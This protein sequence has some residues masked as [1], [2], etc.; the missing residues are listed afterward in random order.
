MALISE[1]SA[2]ITTGV[3]VLSNQ[4]RVLAELR[5]LRSVDEA[6]D[7]CATEITRWSALR[8]VATQA[9]FAGEAPPI[10]SLLDAASALADGLTADQDRQRQS[11]RRAIETLRD[12]VRSSTTDLT[13]AWREHVANVAASSRGMSDLAAAFASVPGAGDTARRLQ[14]VITELAALGQRQP[15]T[16]AVARLADLRDLVPTLLGSLVG[17][18]DSVR[19]F[20]ASLARGGASIEQLTPEVLAWM[21]TSGFLNSFK[22]VAG[23]PAIAQGD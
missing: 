8:A 7:A 20:A 14:S 10:G 21:R 13:T 12:A 1:L 3:D 4:D 11:H 2:S 15:S 23:R 5:D 17:D 6:V 9:G 16:E 18:E 22:I 19:R